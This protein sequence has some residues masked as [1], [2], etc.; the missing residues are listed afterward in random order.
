MHYAPRPA[1]IRAPHDMT[2]PSPLASTLLRYL[3]WRRMCFVWW[4]ALLNGEWGSPTHGYHARYHVPPAPTICPGCFVPLYGGRFL[5]SFSG[6]SVSS[7]ASLRWNHHELPQSTTTLFI[8]KHNMTKIIEVKSPLHHL[9]KLRDALAR[10]GAGADN[11]DRLPPQIVGVIPTWGS[12]A[13]SGPFQ[14]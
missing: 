3:V 7:R 4:V 8:T 11:P 10:G 9:R 12:L 1:A 5:A 13:C 14:T 6:L 2:C